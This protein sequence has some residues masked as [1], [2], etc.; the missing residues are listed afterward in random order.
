MISLRFN[1]Q[2]ENTENQAYVWR[3]IVDGKEHLATDVLC[4]VP[5]FGTKDEIAEGVYKWHLSCDGVLT[6]EGTKAVIRAPAMT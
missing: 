3:I 4:L 2:Y 1:T 5:T 6:W